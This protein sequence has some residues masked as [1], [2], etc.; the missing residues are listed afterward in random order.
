MSTKFLSF[1]VVASVSKLSEWGE[2]SPFRSHIYYSVYHPCYYLNHRPRSTTSPIPRIPPSCDRN[3]QNKLL[4]TP[5][6]PERDS[7][8]GSYSA[9]RYKSRDCAFKVWKG[10]RIFRSI[11]VACNLCFFSSSRTWRKAWTSGKW[12]LTCPMFVILYVNYEK[13]NSQK[14]RTNTEMD[15]RK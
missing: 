9:T 1:T 10:Y 6:S 4:P 13:F 11:H 14:Q 12:T 3:E 15:A 7:T 8:P 5:R 2:F